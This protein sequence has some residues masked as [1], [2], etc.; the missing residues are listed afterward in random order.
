[1][2]AIGICMVRQQAAEA[3]MQRLRILSRDNRGP[4]RMEERETDAEGQASIR[5]SRRAA[6]EDVGG[7]AVHRL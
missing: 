4:R 7:A 1:M 5:I 6:S 3:D 2:A